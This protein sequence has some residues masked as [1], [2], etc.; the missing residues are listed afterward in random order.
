MNWSG[1]LGSG[2]W[3]LLWCI[4]LNEHPAM[5]MSNVN[6]MGRGI[7]CPVDKCGVISLEISSLQLYM[8]L[9]W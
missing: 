3:K 4:F 7:I 9:N 5:S 6:G 8:K 1:Q 2:F